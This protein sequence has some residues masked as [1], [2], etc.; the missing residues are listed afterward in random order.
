[1]GLVERARLGADFRAQRQAQLARRRY[2]H[3]VYTRESVAAQSRKHEIQGRRR[4]WFAGAYW[5]WGFH[6]D[7]M[8]SGVDVAR[9]LGVEWPAGNAAGAARPPLSPSPHRLDTA[10]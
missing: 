6:E 3:P 7:G 5:G 2:R 10:A 8:R 1:M 9:A 4:T